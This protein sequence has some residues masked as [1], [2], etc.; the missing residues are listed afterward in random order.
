M[1]TTALLSYL[2]QKS[3]FR[4]WLRVFSLTTLALFCASPA[5]AETWLLI[6]QTGARPNRIAYFVNSFI[7]GRND[8]FLYLAAIKK[9]QAEKT[10]RNQMDAR[11]DAL[12]K[13]LEVQVYQVL[14][15][16]D[17]PFVRDLT[18]IFDCPANTVTVVRN[19][20]AHHHNGRIDNGVTGG[21]HPAESAW[22]KKVRQASCD[23]ASVIDA[24]RLDHE[25]GDKAQIELKKLG[26][27]IAVKG[28]AY[29]RFYDFA[30]EHL[31][32]DGSKRELSS[33]KTPEQLEQLRM[34]AIAKNEQAG[35]A[36]DAAIGGLEAQLQGEDAERAFINAVTATF[37]KKSEIRRRTMGAQAG[38]TEGEL[39]AFWGVPQQVSELAGA[40]VLVYRKESDE[41]VTQNTVDMRSGQVVNSSTTGQ[42]RQ[43]ELSLFLKPGG[44]VP[45]PRLVDFQMGGENCNIDTLGKNRPR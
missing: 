17:G 24:V 7:S 43:C 32:K 16:P 14:E 44:K 11:L 1:K 2:N 22:L 23:Q 4:A 15:N 29:W 27:I 13:R 21:P 40:R 20:E 38:W 36:I 39:I 33:D 30:W 45:G 9:M 31:W 34:E 26:M 37:A 19:L 12:H 8:P 41:R 25:R 5:I 28:Y 35:K 18:L 42:L 3:G 10:P 6:G